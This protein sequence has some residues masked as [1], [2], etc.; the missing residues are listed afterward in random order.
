MNPDEA[1]QPEQ[2]S[3]V[4]VAPDAPAT[5]DMPEAPVIEDMDPAADLGADAL[6]SRA[7][8]AKILIE[9]LGNIRS[10]RRTG[11]R[12]AYDHGECDPFA[13]LEE[14][15]EE[16]KR[17][18]LSGNDLVPGTKGKQTFFVHIFCKFMQC[19][20][21]LECGAERPDGSAIEDEEACKRYMLAR[22]KALGI[23]AGVRQVPLREV[24][25]HYDRQTH[26][27]WGQDH[28]GV[29]QTYSEGAAAKRLQAAGADAQSPVPWELSPL[30]R[31]LVNIRDTNGIDL[32]SPLAGYT[33]GIHEVKGLRILV[34]KTYH[35]P[36]P[37][38][39]SVSDWKHINA[40][41]EGLLGFGTVDKPG[42]GYYFC[43]KLKCDRA[44]LTA[45][46]KSGGLATL[47]AGV[48]DTGK[49]VLLKIIR[50]V[51]GGRSASA[52]GYLTEKTPFNKDL[53]SAEVHQIDDGNP[54]E[55]RVAR[56]R[57]ANLIKAS[58]ATDECWVHAKGKDGFTLPLYRRLFIL[59][60]LDS[61]DSMPEL[62]E[63]LMDKVM[64]LL[65]KPFKMADGLTPLPSMNDAAA[66]AA[67][68]ALL[69]AEA[70]YFCWWLDNF[71]FP[72]CL[73]ERRFGTKPFKNPQ[74]LARI[75]ELSANDEIQYLIQRVLFPRE[76]LK[77]EKD[78]SLSPSMPEGAVKLQEGV[79]EIE[80]NALLSALMGRDTV[81]RA[82]RLV[83]SAKALGYALRE[84]K[85][86]HPSMYDFRASHGRSYWSVSQ[87]VAH[88]P[89]DSAGGH[90]QKPSAP[91]MP[92]NGHPDGR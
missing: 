43:H 25:L 28:N 31:D 4:P 5:P 65:A 12:G 38:K 24:E 79:V 21:P 29:W 35:L 7:D 51:M 16:L 68:T 62:E 19:D 9:K 85:K 61:L 54:F 30:D 2:Q 46:I 70:P 74:L 55:D 56:R 53:C 8:R 6:V 69:E 60:N 18:R 63:S 57:F 33:E 82:K 52:G 77:F 66:Y 27:F 67:F 45:G 41:I 73:E 50:S 87:D 15:L 80:V 42:Q 49:T 71:R 11:R 34:T 40:I 89:E 36:S 91:G 92:R 58:V 78:G 10:C 32:A 48:T 76:G 22:I 39:G 75:R 72:S 14:S 23:P 59:T 3:R 37:V 20:C 17:S 83:G 1:N 44:A 86:E 88:V 84:L 13:A 81:E 90:H 64:L 26:Y 47:I